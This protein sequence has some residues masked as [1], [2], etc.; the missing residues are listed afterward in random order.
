MVSFKIFNSSEQNMEIIH[1]PECF[2]F[3][4]PV[5]EE[6]LVEIKP[7]LESVQL[8][9]YSDNGRIVVS[10]LDENSKYNVLHDGKDVFHH[11]KD[12]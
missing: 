4:L 8:K 5:N 1:E 12:F 3:D 11:L 10:I 6:V 7:F 9:I 2:A